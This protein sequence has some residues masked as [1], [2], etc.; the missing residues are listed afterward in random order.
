MTDTVELFASIPPPDLKFRL[1]WHAVAEIEPR[2]DLGE[3]PFGHRFIVPIRGGEVVGAPGLEML[4]GEIV[5]GGADRQLLRADG[6]KQLEAI[7]EIRTRDGIVL[8]I[9]N[10]VLIEEGRDPRYAMSRIEVTAPAGP[11]DWLNR[12]LILGTLQSARPRREGVIIRAFEAD[13]LYR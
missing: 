1:L 11:L 8:N 9:C 10:R 6:V 2:Q 7:Y 4:S 5:P 13:A 3:G 12:R